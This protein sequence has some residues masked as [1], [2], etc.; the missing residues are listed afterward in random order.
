MFLLLSVGT[1]WVEQEIA[2]N[3]NE[4]IANANLQKNIGHTKS[5]RSCKKLFFIDCMTGMLGNTYMPLYHLSVL[6]IS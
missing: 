3:S 5:P 2:V 6:S 1:K 4:K